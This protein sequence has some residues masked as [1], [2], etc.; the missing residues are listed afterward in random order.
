MPTPLTCEAHKTTISAAS[1]N[2]D[3]RCVTGIKLRP[4]SSHCLP[5]PLSLQAHMLLLAHLERDAVP[6][7]VALQ[8]DLKFV[9]QKSPV[10]LE[11]MFK[12]ASVPRPP[13][14]YGWLVCA[15]DWLC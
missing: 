15:R 6:I 10:L 1:H 11:E 7:P 14:G 8:A 3:L 5:G 13:Y 9:L 4:A 2:A 12:I